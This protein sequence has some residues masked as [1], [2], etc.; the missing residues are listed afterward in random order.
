MNP[1]VGLGQLNE[2]QARCNRLDALIKMSLEQV[3][4]SENI[5]M[6]S[7]FFDDYDVYQ[8]KCLKLYDLQERIKHELIELG[9]IK[10][11]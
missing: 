7:I 3:E 5:N 10:G 9:Y 11:D 8:D 4:L 1:D 2:L 6:R